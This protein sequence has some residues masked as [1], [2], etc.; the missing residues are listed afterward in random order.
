MQENTHHIALPTKG[1]TALYLS[2]ALLIIMIA[3]S[4][5]LYGYDMY[6]TREIATQKSM[7]TDTEKQIS[8]IARDRDIIIT[9]IAESNTIR[10]SLDLRTLITQ[11]K[12]AAD[13]ENVRLKGF[14]VKNDTITTSLI[15]TE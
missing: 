10:P 6:L 2:V 5:G 13:E 15:A 1:R 14:S 3:G 9:K 4:L 8:E 12:A 7:I 11:F